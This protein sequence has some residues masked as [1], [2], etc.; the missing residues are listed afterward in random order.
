MKHAVY[1]Y[2][3]DIVVYD[4]PSDIDWGNWWSWDQASAYDPGRSYD[5]V[6][7]GTH[8]HLSL[9]PSEDLN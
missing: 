9:S 1:F 5:Y 3:P 4:Y 2:Q 8:P 7:V 6:H